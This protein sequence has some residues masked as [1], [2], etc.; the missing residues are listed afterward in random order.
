MLAM[1]ISGGQTGVDRVALDV[2]MQFGIPHGGWCPAGRRSEDG[3]I[4]EIYNLKETRS[5]SYA[6]RTEQNVLDA[7][8]TLILYATEMTGG[9]AFTRQMAKRH[10]RPFHPVD[11]D[12]MFGISTLVETARDWLGD[13]AVQVL[14]VAGPRASSRRDIVELA[15]KFLTG[16]LREQASHHDGLQ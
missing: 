14:N 10:G 8:A 5:S 1:V 7:D 6:V 2:A 9:T 13:E 16:L 15:T 4:P 3:R 12:S 11:L